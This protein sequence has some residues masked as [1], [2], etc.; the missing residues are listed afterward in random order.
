MVI[1]L[2]TLFGDGKRRLNAGF[3]P[4]DQFIEGDTQIM[5]LCE[6]L[7]GA[8]ALICVLSMIFICMDRCSGGGC[9]AVISYVRLISNFFLYLYPML[10]AGYKLNRYENLIRHFDTPFSC[11]L[12]IE[13]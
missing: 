12:F 9:Q 4:R 13:A 2:E 11:W 6:F 7:F 10:Y 5:Y 1:S 3:I 8:H